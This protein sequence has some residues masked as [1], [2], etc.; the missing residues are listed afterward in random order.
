MLHRRGLAVGR[1]ALS[2]PVPA[3]ASGVVLAILA[4][5]ALEIPDAR[6]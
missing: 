5:R 4:P 2:P 6:T 3:A 1:L